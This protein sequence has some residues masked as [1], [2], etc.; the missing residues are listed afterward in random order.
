M[1]QQ[2]RDVDSGRLRHRLKESG[3]RVSVTEHVGHSKLSRGHALHGV[4]TQKNT[5]FTDIV[6]ADM[7]VGY[8]GRE[9]ADLGGIGLDP[10]GAKLGRPGDV[11]EIG[12]EADVRRSGAGGGLAERLVK[13]AF[14]TQRP[15]LFSGQ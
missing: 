1:G 5:I 9:L 4:T 8:F 12:Q 7:Q 11:V 6:Y 10:I 15:D 2:R 13:P 3:V 14:F